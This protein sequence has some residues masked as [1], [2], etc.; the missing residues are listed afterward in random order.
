MGFRDQDVSR[1]TSR[2][3]EGPSRS[4]GKATFT[5][6]VDTPITDTSTSRC[7]ASQRP[8]AFQTWSLL[9]YADASAAS[10]AGRCSGL[11]LRLWSGCSTHR[12]PSENLDHH[13]GQ[14][15]HRR[16]T[17]Q[18]PTQ[19]PPP[20]ATP[21]LRARLQVAL[22]GDTGRRTGPSSFTAGGNSQ[23]SLRSVPSNDARARDEI[24]ELVPAR[25]NREGP[26]RASHLTR[27]EAS[28]PEGSDAGEGPAMFHVKR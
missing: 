10:R 17:D 3:H 4:I 25:P 23:L 18:A 28:R 1:G 13:G 26:A 11:M 19:Q 6:M 20:A 24:R 14:S 7:L 12:G 16:C 9:S 5:L 21:V 15:A 2:S 8:N 27:S 22:S